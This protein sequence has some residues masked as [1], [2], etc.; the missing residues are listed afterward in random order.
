MP[1]RNLEVKGFD[2]SSPASESR[3]TRHSPFLKDC[4]LNLVGIFL[5]TTV[6]KLL[7]WSKK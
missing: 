3:I 7:A 2:K 4:S 6:E 5:A 1:N